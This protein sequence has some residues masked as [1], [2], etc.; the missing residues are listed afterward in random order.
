MEF[1]QGYYFKGR[2]GMQNTSEINHTKNMMNNIKQMSIIK[3]KLK[4][5]EG[6]LQGKDIFL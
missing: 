6:F 2:K 5:F 4:G 1:A 3:N